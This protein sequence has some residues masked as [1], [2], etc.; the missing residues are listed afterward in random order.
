MDAATTRHGEWFAAVAERFGDGLDIDNELP[1]SLLAPDEGDVL[2]ALDASIDSDR[3]TV[4]YRILVAL[5]AKWSS[6]GRP[7][8]GERVAMWLSTRSPSD[9]E[10]MWAAAVARACFERSSNPDS[11]IHQFAEEAMAISELVGDVESAR[12]LTGVH[13]LA[14]EVGTARS[15]RGDMAD[16]P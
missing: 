1:M 3:P 16:R 11:P 5:G 9:G 4:A 7:E 12:F 6:I 15:V 8:V 13:R 2:A 10:E 14:G